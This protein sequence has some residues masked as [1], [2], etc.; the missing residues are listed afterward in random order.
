M[1]SRDAFN[2]SWEDVSR[3][4]W[5]RYPNPY[6]GHVLTEDIISRYIARDGESRILDTWNMM[7]INLTSVRLVFISSLLHLSPS[8][9]IPVDWCLSN[10]CDVTAVIMLIRTTMMIFIF[11]LRVTRNEAPSREDQSDASCRRVYRRQDWKYRKDRWG[12]HRGSCL[13]S[14][15]VTRWRLNLERIII[16]LI[17]TYRHLFV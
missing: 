2:F 8:S 10:Y 7:T 17:A 3:G 4:F 9:L 14:E 16:S 1:T 11:L 6:S 5:R 12:K 13:Q 15:S